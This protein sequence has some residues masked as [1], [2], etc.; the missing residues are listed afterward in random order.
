[1]ENMLKVKRFDCL[2]IAV[3][4]EWMDFM[5]KLI[6]RYFD[7]ETA[8][9]IYMTAGGKERLD[10]IRNVTDAI[11]EHFAISAED[12]I[13]IHDAARPFVTE[14][15]L[16]DSI[17]SALK[18]GAVVAALP[19]SDTILHSYDREEVA[20]IPDRSIVF[21]GQAPDGRTEEDYHRN[22]TDLYT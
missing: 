22:L 3:H 9:K 12:V 2:F 16:N 17:D 18:Y 15:I 7:E 10:S 20:D 1:M 21:H 19:A 4:S 5:Q 14:Q 8:A 6:T 11:R 13:V